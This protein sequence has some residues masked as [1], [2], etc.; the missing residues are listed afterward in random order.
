MNGQPGYRPPR[1]GRTAL[2]LSLAV[3][4][5]L[6]LSFAS[7]P[8]YDLFC[9]VTGYAGTTQRADAGDAP[10]GA[11]SSRVFTV[12]FDANTASDL[13]WTFR[14]EQRSVTVRP[15][16]QKL[17]FYK[18]VNNTNRPVT[19]RA[20]F[21]VTP[22]KSGQYFVKIACF[23]FEEQTLQPGQEVDMPVT[24]YVDPAVL[25][26][27]NLDEVKTITLS[28][29]FFRAQDDETRSSAAEPRSVTN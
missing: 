15:G 7:V 14:P 16:E 17:V 24:F 11:I 8:L 25:D 29:T 1:H 28:Y 3:A 10:G 19:G 27:R 22:D 20:T 4:G 6:G 23:C 2:V 26:D 5:M 12:N 13:P 9:R 18:A 21:N